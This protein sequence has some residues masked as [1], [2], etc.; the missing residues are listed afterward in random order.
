[1]PVPILNQMFTD[2]VDSIP[3]VWPVLKT[4]PAFAALYL[5]KTFCQ[6]ASNTSER[7]LHGKVV[8][9]TVG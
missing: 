6:G 4:L 7:N 3:F 8:V 1:M 2:G 5:V 9:V